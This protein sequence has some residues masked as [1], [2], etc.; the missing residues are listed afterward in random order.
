MQGIAHKWHEHLQ[1]YVASFSFIH[2]NQ[3][4]ADELNNNTTLSNELET[5]LNK[6]RAL[7]CD[8]EHFV[9]AT[10]NKHGNNIPKWYSLGEMSRIV[11]KLKNQKSRYNNL[12]VKARFQQYVDRLYKRIQS[13]NLTKNM[14]HKSLQNKSRRVKTTLKSRRRNRMN[15]RRT[16]TVAY[17]GEPTSTEKVFIIT[18]RGPRRNTKVGRGLKKGNRIN[19]S[20]Q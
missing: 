12:F 10:S 9:N 1:I 2:K 11:W 3:T 6:A 16:T 8:I 19:H 17:T 14:E 20:L 18:T 7:L 15:K 5:I 4:K 13:F